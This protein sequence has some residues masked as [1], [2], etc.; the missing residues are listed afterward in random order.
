MAAR[1]RGLFNVFRGRA[2]GGIFMVRPT[3]FADCPLFR[4]RQRRPWKFPLV[5]FPSVAV[6][7]FYATEIPILSC[8]D[9]IDLESFLVCATTKDCGV[10]DPVTPIPGSAA[11]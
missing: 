6:W 3:N 1:M 10:V 7:I 9:E 8:R 11:R 2:W 5:E 4:Q